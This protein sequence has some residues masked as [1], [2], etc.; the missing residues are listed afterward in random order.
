MDLFDNE[1]LFK[2][3]KKKVKR[4]GIIIIS[5]IVVAIFLIIGIVF[6][7]SYFQS[8]QLGISV[9]GVS[10]PIVEGKTVIY[11]ESQNM[12]I[13]IQE[14]ATKVPGY[15]YLNGK[16]GENS[17]NTEEGVVQSQ[18][19]AV[20]FSMNENKIEKILIN[21]DTEDTEY[22]Y[23]YL[24]Y[25]IKYQNGTLYAYVED[26]KT[27]FNA[28]VE[29]NKETNKVKLTS[30]ETLYT[31]YQNVI[32]T[33]GNLGYTSV[34]SSFVNKK[35]LASDLI[36][37]KK[38]SGGYGILRPDGT[39]VSGPRYT[40]IKYLE[41]TEEF[42]VE[43]NGKYG[44]ISNLG[45]SKVPMNYED[46]KLLDKDSGLYIV[47]NSDKYGVINK[48]GVEVLYIEFDQIGVD[49]SQYPSLGNE[50]QY[51]FYDTIIPVSRDDKWGL[52][53]V[54]GEEILP[55][56][57]DSIGCIVSS[58]QSASVQNAILLDDYEGII[59][60]QQIAENN[61]NKK[62]AV[63]NP[64]GDQLVDFQL[65]NIYYRTENGKDV[66]YLEK[67][68][69]NGLLDEVFAQNGINKV[70]KD[71]NSNLNNNININNSITQSN[72]VV[73]N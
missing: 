14:V 32:Q 10:V 36:V 60:G 19:E 62:Y 49:K 63:Y 50:N 29:Y 44:I 43:S 46:I 31:S 47:K 2:E 30:T 55:V 33:L 59:V 13:N 48:D 38:D 20:Q 9:D 23:M 11:D 26:L 67:D 27:L 37:A 72:T 42:L 8:M 5:C 15:S 21:E 28:K 3:E 66:Y 1:E 39:E 65:D 58:R 53:N 69:Q 25:P 17:E 51:L 57:Y 41:T 56:A 40:S 71:V 18:N 61:S 16:Y 52:Y 7:M 35:A 4:N 68:G 70:T 64:L 34:E 6:A 12:F 73:T 54:R 22:G 45:Q 24:K